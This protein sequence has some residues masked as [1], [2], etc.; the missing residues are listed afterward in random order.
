VIS[1]PYVARYGPPHQPAEEVGVL[2]EGGR[3]CYDALR[4]YSHEDTYKLV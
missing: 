2:L 3:H 1:M 4:A